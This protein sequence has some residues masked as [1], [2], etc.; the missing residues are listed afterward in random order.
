MR[1]ITSKLYSTI[2]GSSLNI[3]QTK[4]QTIFYYPCSSWDECTPY[5]VDLESGVYQFE[6]W[7]AQGGG[8]EWETCTPF[9]PGGKGGYTSGII[10][11]HERSRFYLFI[12]AHNF[13][14]HYTW[15]SDNIKMAYNGGGFAYY[16]PGG[17]GGTDIRLFY[18]NQID[19]DQSLRSRIIVSGGGGGSDCLGVGGH[20]GGLIGET[21]SGGGAGGS[22]ESGGAGNPSGNYWS[23][24]SSTSFDAAGGAGGY[25]GGGYGS[26]FNHGGGGGSSYVSGFPD[27]KTYNTE[28][29]LEDTPYHPS[30]KFFLSPV[31]IQGGNEMPSP[32]SPHVIYGQEGNGAARITLIKSLS[33]TQS[34]HRS[35]FYHITY[36]IILL[37]YFI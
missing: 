36:I 1:Y 11:L 21:P 34:L 14:L 33:C 3:S 22:Q 10:Q 27:C 7:G 26:S 4:K 5:V 23:G 9:T 20:G 30:G 15:P 12:G 16:S 24:G 37:N 35:H 8:V 31:I 28:G 32:D 29:I 17:G 6:L 18:H 25:F 13:D 2:S 19:S